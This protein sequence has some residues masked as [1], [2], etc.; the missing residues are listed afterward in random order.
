MSPKQPT[1]NAKN[2][3]T[4]KNFNWGTFAFV[5]GLGLAMSSIIGAAVISNILA[6]RWVNDVTVYNYTGSTHVG[7][8]VKYKENPPVAGDHAAAWQNCGF[9]DQPIPNETA[10][11]SL[12]HGA[13]WLTYRPE[14]PA[15][16]VEK[17]RAFTER[18]G[19]VLVSPNVG[20][21]KDVIA[22]AWNHQLILDGIDDDRL[23]KFVDRYTQGPQTPEL[24]A[25]CTNG[26]GVPR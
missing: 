20:Q 11:H 9:Y 23:E 10:V 13:V 5:G 17:L 2:K 14:L 21:S 6:D 3:K 12:E 7:E 1:P 16:Q 15:A 19:Y 25:A 24:G 22:S 26:F 8:P 4:K 18:S